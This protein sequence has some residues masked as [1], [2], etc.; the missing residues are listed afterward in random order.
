[1]EE[2]SSDY[3]RLNIE[4]SVAPAPAVINKNVQ[5]GTPKN[6]VLDLRWFHSD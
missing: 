6:I 3:E 2:V 4:M 5:I 1:M